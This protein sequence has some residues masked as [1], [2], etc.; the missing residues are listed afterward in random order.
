MYNLEIDDFTIV[1][2]SLYGYGKIFNE[3]I[4]S[5]FLTLYSNRWATIKTVVDIKMRGGAESR[6]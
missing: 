3:S 6:L 1:I 5:A 2:R 4:R